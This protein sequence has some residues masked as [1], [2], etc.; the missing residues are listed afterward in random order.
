MCVT[1]IFTARV[2]ITRYVFI[3]QC[4]ILVFIS[5]SIFAISIIDL[6]IRNNNV[7]YCYIRSIYILLFLKLALLNCAA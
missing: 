3:L 4:I 6:Y 7:L 2:D 1:H 5:I